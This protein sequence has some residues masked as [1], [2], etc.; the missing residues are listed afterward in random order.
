MLP[1]E[2]GQWK[3]CKCAPALVVVGKRCFS[4]AGEVDGATL[5]EEHNYHKTARALHEMYQIVFPAR[6]GNW[7]LLFDLK[8]EPVWVPLK[9]LEAAFKEP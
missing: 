7:A 3:Y 5:F 9:A 1:D 8:A 6:E 2:L 4:P